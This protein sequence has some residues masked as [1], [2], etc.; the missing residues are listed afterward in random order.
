MYRWCGDLRSVSQRPDMVKRAHRKGPNRETR[1][2]KST[3]VTLH[4]LS[5]SQE[6]THKKKN[7][8]YLHG[9]GTEIEGWSFPFECL[10]FSN[11]LFQRLFCHP[12]QL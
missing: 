3:I 9:R 7:E 4:L 1:T 8:K 10:H 2:D 12:E 6:N 11:A 5:A